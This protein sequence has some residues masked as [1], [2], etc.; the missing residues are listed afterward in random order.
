MTAHTK[1]SEFV[2]LVDL[3]LTAPMLAANA[4]TVTMTQ[5]SG[6]VSQA[7]KETPTR[8]VLVM[9]F[10]F[11]SLAFLVM[12]EVASTILGILL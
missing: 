4:P 7:Y 2:M 3:F 6:L 5:K 8:M 10:S 1:Y 11:I 12:L 9:M